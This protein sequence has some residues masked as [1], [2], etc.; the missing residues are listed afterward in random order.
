[1]HVKGNEFLIDGIVIR[2]MYLNET[3]IAFGT[4]QYTPIDAK[5]SKIKSMRNCGRMNL[6]R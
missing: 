1:M 5:R 2:K 3:A 4:I 6:I